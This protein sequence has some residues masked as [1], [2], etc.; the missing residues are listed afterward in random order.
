MRSGFLH[1][2]HHRAISSILLFLFLF[3]LVDCSSTEQQKGEDVLARSRREMVERDL[4]GRG[5]KDRRVLEAM[6]V[7]PRHLFVEHKQIPS[8]YEDRPLPIGEGQTISQPYVVAL[9]SELLELKGSEKVLEVGT[10][11]GYQASVLSLLAKEIYTIEIIPSLAERARATLRDLGYRNV[12]VKMGDGFFGWE[13][14]GPFDAILMTASTEKIP[15][16]LWQQL[17][18]G[19]R[20]VMPLG[21]EGKPQTLIRASKTEGRRHVVDVGPVMFV[22]MVGAAQKRSR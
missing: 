3:S 22:P 16:P 4:S 9:M 14:K 21:G 5:I 17:R 12:W 20:L 10:G 11:S 18:E 1:P 13:E 2:V 15:E 8:A 7:V 6:G 19:G